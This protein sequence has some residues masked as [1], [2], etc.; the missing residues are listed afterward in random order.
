MYVKQIVIAVYALMIIAIGVAG[1]RKTRSFSDF[2][3]GGGKVGPWMTA[4]TYAASYFSAVLFIGFAGKIGWGFGYSG[5]WIAVGNALVGVLAVWWLLGYRV[6]QIARACDIHTMPEFFERRYNSTFLKLFASVAI[7]V[8]FVPYSS[9]VFMGLSYLFQSNFNI[10]YGYALAAMGAFTAVYMVLGGYKSMAMI[11][12]IFGLIMVAGVCILLWFTIDEGGGLRKMSADLAAIDPK[13]AAPVG[14]PGVWPLFCLVFLTSV[15]PF[16]MPQLVQKFYA[17]KD[18][19]SVRIGMVAST[20]FAVLIGGAAYFTGATTRLFISPETAPGIFEQGRPI[21]D[22]L[23]PELLAHV[24]PESLSVLMLLLVLSASMSTLAALV[25]LSSS[26]VVK[27]FYAG[28]VNKNVSDRQ[29]MLLMRVLSAVFIVVSVVLAAAR[30]ET[31]VAILAI[32]WGAIGSV[33]LGP[34]VWGIFSRRVNR[35]G[36]ISSA[37]LGL[38]VCLAL[39]IAGRPRPEA[40]T[41]GMIV[42]LVI[43]PLFSRLA[44]RSANPGIPA[45]EPATPTDTRPD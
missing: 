32:S 2:F 42:S 40:G 30:L 1:W 28:F 10:P 36:A 41:I 16:G 20:C 44:P 3:L 6:R 38:G 31:I 45:L 9:A 13:L 21:V 27:D 15:A 11:D 19:R 24:V 39:Y 22:R 25:L 35:F 14:P 5:L 12:V 43:N 34:F 8:F 7:F 23:M 4:F 33:F 18:R 37:V 26:A 17:I 29:L